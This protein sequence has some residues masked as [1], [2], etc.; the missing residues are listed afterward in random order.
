MTARRQECLLE[1]M[2]FALESSR[3]L[4]AA[5]TFPRNK[6]IAGSYLVIEWNGENFE[7]PSLLYVSKVCRLH[8][9]PL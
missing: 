5:T 3:N 2:S 8:T 4:E 6:T 7:T 9:D 1:V